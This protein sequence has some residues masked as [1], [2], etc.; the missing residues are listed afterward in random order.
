MVQHKQLQTHISVEVKTKENRVS[1]NY[2]G[3]KGLAI[4]KR[5]ESISVECGRFSVFQNKN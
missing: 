5:I 1:Q 3:H 4:L 2:S